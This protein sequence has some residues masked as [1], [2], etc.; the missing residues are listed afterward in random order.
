MTKT[1][2][3]VATA[4]LIGG[5][6]WSQENP[7]IKKIGGNELKRREALAKAKT[8]TQ[9]KSSGVKTRGI[10]TRGISIPEAKVVV[11]EKIAAK[12]R[13][14]IFSTRGIG[15]VTRGIA[16]AISATDSKSNVA[17]KQIVA[18]KENPYG[19]QGDLA[20]KPGEKAYEMSYSVDPSSEL[21]GEIRFLK[22]KTDIADSESIQFINQLAE[23]INHPKLNGFK[24]VIEGHASAEGSA[25]GNQRLSQRRANAIFDILTS[26]GYGVHPHRLLPVGFGESEARFPPTAGEIALAQDR[27]VLIFKLED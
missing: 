13:S 6:A 1:L 18:P 26:P 16:T 7:L 17:V 9:T 23:A 10:K 11:P 3:I 12:K 8:Q 21:K 5:F 15:D 2:S 19:K 27:R 20:A 4:L 14:V 25:E 22:G 24:F